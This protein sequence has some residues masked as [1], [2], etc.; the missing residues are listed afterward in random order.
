VSGGALDLKRS[1]EWD[2]PVPQLQAAAVRGR[3]DS[4]SYLA[5]SASTSPGK[6]TVRAS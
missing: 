2:L 3:I 5:S 6:F 1:H 4:C